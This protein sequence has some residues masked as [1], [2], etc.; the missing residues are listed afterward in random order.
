MKKRNWFIVA[1]LIAD[2]LYVYGFVL[3]I[4]A[5]IGGAEGDYEL[6]VVFGVS[7]AL[8]IAG[9]G[10]ARRHL[11]AS[12]VQPHHAAMAL[13]L[14][15]ILLS[16][17]STFPFV[18]HGLTWMDALFEAFSAWTDTGLTMIPEPETL[19]YALAFFR[20]LM[21]WIS[22]LGIVLFMLALRGPSPKAAQ[23]LFEAEGRFEDFTTDLWTVGRTLVLIYAGYTV[24]GFVGLWATGVPPFDALAH[25]ITSLSTGGFSTNSVGVGLYGPLPSLVAMGLMLAG[26]ISFNSHRA[27]LAG[28][29]RKFFRNPEVRALLVIITVATA[30]LLLAGWRRGWATGPMETLFYVI[31]AVTSCGAG[32]RPALG[33]MPTLLIV[34]VILLMIG[35][36]VYGSTTGGIKLWRLLIIAQVIR[37][38]MRRPFYPRGTVMPIR[39]G[40]HVIGDQ[41]AL[42]VA[43]YALLYLAMGVAGSIVFVLFGYDVLASLFIVFSAQGT[44][45]LNIIPD[46]PYYGMPALLKAQLIL[47]MLMGRMEILPLFYLLRGFRE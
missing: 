29:V 39:M 6:G 16:L 40:D 9:G 36:A 24:A 15:W 31:S 1:R 19:P 42:Q 30:F 28:N 22:G 46:A 45:G 44:V 23:R 17:V 21:Q 8:L 4:P 7:A 47:H 41:V 13:A 18:V 37:R 35:G 14:T 43:A 2:F 5:L 27:L 3:W 10:L 20:V 11:S 26:G 38:E 12:E 25:A 34:V 33:E 32:T